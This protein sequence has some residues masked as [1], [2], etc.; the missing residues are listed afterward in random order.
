MF[1]ASFGCERQEHN[2]PIYLINPSRDLLKIMVLLSSSFN[3]YAAFNIYAINKPFTFYSCVMEE[4]SKR[5]FA[6]NVYV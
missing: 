6:K 2:V 1:E 3:S 5:E 4:E